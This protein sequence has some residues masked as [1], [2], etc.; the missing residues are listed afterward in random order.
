MIHQIAYHLILG[1][2][3]IMYLGIITF[4]SLLT[5]IFISV[6]NVKYGIHWIPFKYHPIM[7]G[8]T[9]ALATIHAILGLSLYF[10]F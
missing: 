1:K 8:V 3:A 4:L 2:P 10:N 9:L 6:S 5:T 7:A